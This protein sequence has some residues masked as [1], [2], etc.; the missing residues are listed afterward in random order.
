MN[1]KIRVGFFLLSRE[2]APIPSTRIAI[3]NLFPFFRQANI[4]P[5]IVFQPIKPTEQPDVS[6]IDDQ[7]AALYLDIAVF[8]KVHGPSVEALTMKLRAVGVKTVYCVCD[9]VEIAMAT[10]TD[11]TVVV[12]DYLKSLYPAELQEKIH[13]VHDGIE[14]PEHMKL[15]VNLNRGS[16]S[17]PLNAL[18]VTSAALDCLPTCFPLPDW[19]NLTILGRY[20]N[21]DSWLQ[22]IRVARWDIMGKA[23]FSDKLRCLRFYSNSRIST[24]AWEERIVYE[25]MGSADIGVIPVEMDE[26]GPQDASWR[27]KSENRLTMKMAVGLPVI[28]SPIPSYESVITH[29][30]NGFLARSKSDWMDCLSTL[31]DP[32]TREMVGSEARRSVINRFSMENQANRL[33]TVLKSLLGPL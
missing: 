4:D 20:P 29:G 30:N 27:V 6:A 19:L 10:A 23:S 3:L 1:E 15:N 12:T 32:A 2:D 33:I 18:L 24:K 28:A 17:K 8:Q 22:R 31:R 25:F 16:R 9:L 26:S 21:K 7:I 13:V 11:A 5:I 14:H